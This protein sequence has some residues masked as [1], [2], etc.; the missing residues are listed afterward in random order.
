MIP[1]NPPP[2]PPLPPRYNWAEV[3]TAAL[4]RPSVPTYTELLNDPAA[5]PR[6]A[7]AWIY[8]AALATTFALSYAL[9]S[10]PSLTAALSATPELAGADIQGALL[11][12]LLCVVPF[13]S[14]FAVL[15][16]IALIF[17]MQAVAGLMD[18]SPDKSQTMGR[19]PQLA[20]LMGA[21]LAPLNLLSILFVLLPALGILSLAVTLYQFFLMWQIIRAVYDFDA[22][23]TA[24]ILAVF[25]GGTFLLSGFFL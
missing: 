20:Y 11:P 24:V 13:A 22:P 4:T 5:K 12:S 15:I 3:W 21:I 23:R 8:L 17:L 1:G 10:D 16:F 14:A 25:V 19:F 2:K 9:F 7:Y 18:P 6:R